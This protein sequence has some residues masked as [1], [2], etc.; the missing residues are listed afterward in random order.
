MLDDFNDVINGLFN[1]IG[2]TMTWINV[3]KLYKD[4]RVRGVFY[5]AWIFYSIWGFW[6]LYYYS[7]L[8]QWSSFAAGLF[9]CVANVVWVSLAIYYINKE[10]KCLQ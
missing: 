10:K 7:S 8:K 1:M 4:K 5:Q 3:F 9:I 6:N 2:G